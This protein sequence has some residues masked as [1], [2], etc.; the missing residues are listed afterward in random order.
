MAEVVKVMPP[1]LLDAASQA[2]AHAETAAA[3]HPGVVPAAAPGSSAD[4]AA[5]TIATGMAARSALLSA[6]LAGKAPQVQSATQNGVTQLE[7]QD[8]H[9]ATQISELGQQA[10][11]PQ[12]PPHGGISPAGFG[13]PPPLDPAPTPPADPFAGWTEQQLEQAAVEIAHGHA[14][15]HFPGLSEPDLARRILNVLSDPRSI[16]GTDDGRGLIVLGKD[17]TVVFVKPGDPDFGTAFVPAAPPGA[18]WKT[19][20]DYFDRNARPRVPLPPPPPGRLPPVAP[21]DLAPIVNAPPALPPIG[22]H[23][24]PDPLPP[25]VLDHPPVALPP[26]VVEHPALPP[27]LQDPSPPGFHATPGQP[28]DIFTWDTPDPLP[29]APAPP[30]PA[31]APGPPLTL[32]ASP[33]TP[34]QAAQGG[35]LAGLGAFGAW[36]LSTLPKLVYP[37]R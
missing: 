26:P 36:V 17:G 19:P 2:A 15:E 35:V 9:N 37:G 20:E 33:I 12:T 11:A 7:A 27:W 4:A 29:V 16:G 8:Q 22:Q 10:M 30:P 6:Q 32:P 31:P 14:A 23:P 3:P 24:A 1:A 28:P 5:A 21:G 25:T 34:G 18:D 13:T